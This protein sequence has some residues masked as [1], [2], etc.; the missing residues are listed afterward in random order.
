MVRQRETGKVAF[1]RRLFVNVNRNK[2]LRRAVRAIM[3]IL[4]FR[5]GVPLSEAPPKF[6]HFVVLCRT[7]A[8]NRKIL[9]IKVQNSR[10]NS[11]KKEKF[12]IQN[13]GQNI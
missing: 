1:R 7:L 13:F 4:H 8:Q 5:V 10:K 12:L 11:Y 3:L 9:S 6:T 2:I